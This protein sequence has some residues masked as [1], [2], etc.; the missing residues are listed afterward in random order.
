MI[1]NAFT[2][3]DAPLVKVSGLWPHPQNR[4]IYGE[5]DVSELAAQIDAPGWIKPLT[6]TTEKVIISGHRRWKAAKMLGRT[7]VPAWE[8]SFA[9]PREE[10]EA[11]LRENEFRDK[12]VE[13]KTERG[14]RLGGN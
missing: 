3:L 11:L 7:A 1:A 9:S 2:E 10:L 4:A 8:Q 5:E 6:I 13:Q 14:H 12:T